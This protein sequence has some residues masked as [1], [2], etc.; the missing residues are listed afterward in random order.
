VERTTSWYL[1]AIG[2]RDGQ[3]IERLLMERN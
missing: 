1:D 3:T 2:R